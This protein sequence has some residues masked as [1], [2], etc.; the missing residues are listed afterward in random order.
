MTP[1]L[2][3][4]STLTR[5]KEVFRPIDPSNVRMYACGPTV[6]DDAHIGNARPIIVFDLLFR[7]CATSTARRTSPTPATSPTSTTRSTPRR[8]A[9]LSIRELTDGTL[10]PLP[11]GHS[12][13]RRADARDA[14]GG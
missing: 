8:G 7:C 5:T 14:P 11:R 10:G 1:T 12:G 9:G 2:R 13:A 3:L 6:Y 4:Y